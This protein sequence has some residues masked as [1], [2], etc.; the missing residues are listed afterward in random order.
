MVM[1]QQSE[2]VAER[3]VWASRLRRQALSGLTRFGE[4]EALRRVAGGEGAEGGSGL[5]GSFRDER[6]HRRA[7]DRWLVGRLLGEAVEDEVG[8]R[9]GLDERLFAGLVTGDGSAAEA[10]LGSNGSL[11]V[12]DPEV[13]IERWTQTE[14]GALHAM[15]V[16]AARG[17]GRDRV[18]DAAR[19]HVAELQPDNATHH[20][21]ALHVFVEVGISGDSGAL[22]HAGTLL[23]NAMVAGGGA[24]DAFSSVLLL[25]SA[26]VLEG[27]GWLG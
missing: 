11:E 18:L 12:F 15:G 20:A 8:D 6:G 22:A 17:L 9:A 3:A 27:G 7:V 2:W 10:C 13:G 16:W 5:A 4:A 24:P 25:D 26:M 1:G 14:L 21:W 19:W 23:H